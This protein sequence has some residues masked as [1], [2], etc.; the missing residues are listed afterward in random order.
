MPLLPILLQWLPVVN[1]ACERNLFLYGFKERDIHGCLKIE[2][3]QEAET[4][5]Y[6]FKDKIEHDI[7]FEK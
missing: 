7:L 6:E 5:E 1:A 2:L 3:T 4:G